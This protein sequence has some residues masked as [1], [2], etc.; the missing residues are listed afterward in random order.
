MVGVHVQRSFIALLCLSNLDTVGYITSSLH[1]HYIINTSSHSS[2]IITT[3]I[4]IMRIIITSAQCIGVTSYILNLSHQIDIYG[5]PQCRSLEYQPRNQSAREQIRRLAQRVDALLTRHCRISVTQNDQQVA[6]ILCTQMHTNTCVQ[7]MP[8]R[9]VF[10]GTMCTQLPPHPRTPTF[11]C[12][13]SA[14]ARLQ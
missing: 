14:L 7:C 9:S 6:C 13:F 1:H 11:P 5:Q 10:V 4:H 2:D 8:N 3:S 12:S